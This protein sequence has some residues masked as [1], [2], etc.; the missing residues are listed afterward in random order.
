MPEVKG[1]DLKIKLCGFKDKELVDFACQFDIHFIGFVFYDGSVR[2]V[3]INNIAQ[4]AQ[5]I[6]NH[7]KKVAVLVDASDSKISQI[8]TQLKPDFLQLH[9]G[10]TLK[11]CQEIK[12][13]FRIPIIKAFHIGHKEDLHKIVGFED[14]A[15]YFLFDTKSTTEIGGT[16]TAFDWTI[17]QGFQC[18]K[19][20][21][22]SGGINK[23]NIKEALKISHAKMVDLSSALEEEKGLKSKKLIKD[24][25]T[26]LTIKY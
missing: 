11:R 6:P 19:D 21:F 1:L 8:I 13:K 7:I 18:P 2:N 16:G 12:E 17:L 5:D 9:G 20:Y 4:I 24:F 25:M 26:N 22:L 3:D 15:K 14:V 10:E 23:D